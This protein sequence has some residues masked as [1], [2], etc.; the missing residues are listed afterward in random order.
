MAAYFRAIDVSGRVD[1][2]DVTESLGE[3]PEQLVGR[4]VDL[5]GQEPEVVRVPGEAFEQLLGALDLA[6]PREA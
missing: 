4:G 3:V 6:R 5:F 1:Q 2:P